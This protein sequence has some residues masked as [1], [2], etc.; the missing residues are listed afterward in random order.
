MIFT[1]SA[2]IKLLSVN[3]AFVTLRNGVR[4]RSKD[5]MIFSTEISRLLNENKK[6]FLDFNAHFDPYKHKIHAH[7]IQ[8]TDEL[9]TKDGRISQKSGD[10]GNMEKCITDCILVGSID[11]S[12]ITRWV[13]EKEYRAI[14]GFKISFAE[15]EK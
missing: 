13:L 3:K 12:A 4:C 8:F 7:L 5:Y 9:Y 11:D 1:L 2:N 14:K 6:S 15:L 10:V